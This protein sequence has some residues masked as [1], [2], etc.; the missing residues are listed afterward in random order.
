MISAYVHLFHGDGWH[1]ENPSNFLQSLEDSAANIPGI[2]DSDKCQ[3]FYLKCK[4]DFDAEYWYE[5]LESNSP[6]VLTSWPMFVNHFRVRWLRASPSSLLEPDPVISKKP[7][8]ATPIATETPTTIIMNAN[9][10]I[11]TT[12]PAHCNTSVPT[13]FETTATPKQL[14]QEVDARHV[15]P[16]S[17]RLEV[18]A[19]ST[20]TAADS[21]NA[22]TMA[23]QQD[24]EE[25]TMGR[26]EE[27]EGGIEKQNG[28]SEREADAGGRERVEDTQSEVRDHATLDRTTLRK[29]MQS[30]WA[31]EV[32]K[33]MGPSPVAHNTPQPEPV[34]PVPGEV[35][36][37]PVRTAFANAV[38]ADPVHVNPAPVHL[39]NSDPGDVTVDPVRTAFANMMPA[40]PVHV[41][42]APVHLANSNPG[43]VTVD[44]VH[45]AFANAMPAN[46]VPV[47]PTPV[48]P[49]NP[50]RIP[51][52][53]TIPSNFTTIAS[54]Y[55]DLNPM[56]PTS[57][58]VPVDP[59]PCGETV[60]PALVDT[61]CNTPVEPMHVDPVSVISTDST[62]ISGII[63]FA[64][65]TLLGIKLIC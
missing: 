49:M 40:N 34:N 36:V 55:P 54:V 45:T 32:D 37:D 9:T 13:T 57:S 62:L 52:A 44:P 65:I 42:P 27:Q 24:N 56:H 12:T 8:T 53:N 20:T 19:T 61:I 50:I 31:V 30:D 47:D 39:A 22:I 7:D 60:H 46:P 14:D 5:E 33:A 4:A 15:M 64:F 29:P 23:K 18:K 17:T 59:S 11:T 41:D 26:K 6:M 58:T 16:V 21:N 1:S 48:S 25:P 3:R 63:G 10:V 28:A 2:S 51:F 38:P 43:D 35:T